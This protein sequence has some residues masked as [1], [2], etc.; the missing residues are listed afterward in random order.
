MQI[1][2]QIL[3][4]DRPELYNPPFHIVSHQEN[5][6]C[7]L[8]QHPDSSR[9]VHEAVQKY[10]LIQSVYRNTDHVHMIPCNNVILHDCHKS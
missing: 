10:S 8:C 1:R 9:F 6:K 2:N 7:G 5:H 3:Q 4:A